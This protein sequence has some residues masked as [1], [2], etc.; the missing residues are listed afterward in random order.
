MF[1]ESSRVKGGVSRLLQAFQ[2]VQESSREV[3]RFQGLLLGSRGFKGISWWVSV[4]FSESS[5]SLR[6]I[7]GVPKREHFKG[8]TRGFRRL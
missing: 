2:E 3:E 7:Q 4:G 8:T 5:G 6:G 1:W